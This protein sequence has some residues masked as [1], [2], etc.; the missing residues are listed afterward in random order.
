MR[1]GY[2]LSLF[3]SFQDV[4]DSLINV[5]VFLYIGAIMPW[6]D[7]GNSEI[8]LAAWRLVV[9]GILVLLVRRLPWVLACRKIIPD[10]EDWKEATFT[11][12]FGPIGT[13]RSSGSL[14]RVLVDV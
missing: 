13:S 14:A 3:Q 1:F 9:L 2:S 11:G 4:L 8:G 5:G 6:S 12:W 7:F 10:L